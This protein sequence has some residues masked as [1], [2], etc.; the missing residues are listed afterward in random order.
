MKVWVILWQTPE[1][2]LCGIGGVFHSLEAA[3]EYLPDLFEAGE[4]IEEEETSR[5]AYLYYTNYSTYSIECHTI[6]PV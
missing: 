1:Q 2:C 4:V 3:K 5:G 6:P